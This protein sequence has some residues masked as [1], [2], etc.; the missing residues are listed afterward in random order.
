MAQCK[1]QIFSSDSGEVSY[2]SV[3]N[4]SRRARMQAVA[5][6]CVH[7]LLTVFFLIE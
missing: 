4:L 3:Q 2:D 6:H 5:L 1:P 7:C